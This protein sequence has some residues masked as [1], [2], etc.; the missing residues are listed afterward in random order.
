MVSSEGI[1]MEDKQIEAVKQWQQPQVFLG[2]ANF[3]RRFIQGFSR[4]TAPL[5]SMLKTSNTKSAELKKDGVGVGGDSW[6]GRGGSEIDG[7]RMDNVELDGSEVEVVKV[8]KKVQKTSKSKNLSKSKKTIR[9][10]EFLIP[11]AKLAFTKLR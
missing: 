8:E 4:I 3:Y 2:F 9:S 10:S 5:T 6:A 11:G 7:S 1:C